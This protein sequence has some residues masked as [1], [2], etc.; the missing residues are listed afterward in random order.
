[1]SNILKLYQFNVGAGDHCVLEFPNGEFGIVD[2]HFTGE[3]L[4]QTEAPIMQ[5]FR[6]LKKKKQKIVIAFLCISHYDADHI[7]GLAEFI[8]F[9]KNKKN[10]VEI[11]NI[12]L[13]GYENKDKTKS[14]IKKKIDTYIRQL[15]EGKNLSK[16]DESINIKALQD[17]YSGYNLDLRRL[18]DFVSK[19]NKKQ[20]NAAIYPSDYKILSN[21]LP[22]KF[23]AF[24]I[25]PL[26]KHIQKYKACDASAF[27]K[28]I[29][30]NEY[31]STADNNLISSVIFLQNDKFSFSFGGDT[32][33]E[34]WEESLKFFQKQQYD[35]NLSS[36]FIKVSHH[37]SSNSSSPFIWETLIHNKKKV[38]FGISAGKKHQHPHA[39]TLK[40]IKET[41]PKSKVENIISSTNI[42]KHCIELAP[43]EKATHEPFEGR[44]T[45]YMKNHPHRNLFKQAS[46]KLKNQNQ[47]NQAAHPPS[48]EKGL[49][50]YVYKFDLDSGV[51]D[52]EML[53]CDQT[54]CYQ[55]CLIKEHETKLPNCE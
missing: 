9:A 13:A 39:E 52:L 35:K 18:D 1:M 32:H 48:N 2:F 44:A 7:K 22:S 3:T 16:S 5:F 38:Y 53:L 36:D 6:T 46:N 42:C 30:K 54:G 19:W 15:K 33:K 17:T 40:Q 37:G 55:E 51:S 21:N 11:K 45:A 31:K 23:N 20:N 14:L 29:F 28:S 27:V 4:L 8:K 43:V 41:C 10:N 50:A 47:I 26:S 24:A 49:L 34:V 12:W 25:A